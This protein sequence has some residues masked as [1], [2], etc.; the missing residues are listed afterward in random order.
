VATIEVETTYPVSAQVVWAQL[1]DIERHVAWMHDAQAIS[2]IS[3]QREG[4]GTE[5]NCDTKIGPLRTRDVMIVTEWERDVAM[6][7][8]HKGLI[9]GSGR[10][11]LARSEHQTVVTWRETLH[12]PWW[13]GSR[14][15]ALF[16]KPVLRALWA[17][18]LRQ[19]G[20]RMASS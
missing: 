18:N 17:K 5:F 7:V 3:E 12:F 20:E 2:F 9:T 11:T 4:V 14:V 1:C 13:L 6:G 16:A 10:F 8:T 19:L 15:G